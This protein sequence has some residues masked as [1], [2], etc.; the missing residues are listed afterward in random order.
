[1]T[2]SLQHYR[3]HILQSNLSFILNLR[4]CISRFAGS[5]GRSTQ[6]IHKGFRRNMTCTQQ[7]SMLNT[8]LSH[9]Q[10]PHFYRKSTS[11]GPVWLHHSKIGIERHQRPSKIY[12]LRLSMWNSIHVSLFYSRENYIRIGHL[13]SKTL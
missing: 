9:W 3:L 12:S 4:S 1:M 13:L 8:S 2:S 11:S 5:N 10:L 6:G 7:Q